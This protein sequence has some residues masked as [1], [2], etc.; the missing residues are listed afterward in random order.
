[1]GLEAILSP[2]RRGFNVAG[3]L[4]SALQGV[5]LRVEERKLSGLAGRLENIKNGDVSWMNNLK[6]MSLEDSALALKAAY[7][8]NKVFKDYFGFATDSPEEWQK[9]NLAVVLA[10]AHYLE[11]QNFFLTTQIGRLNSDASLLSAYA[12]RMG[13]HDMADEEA[14][15]FVVKRLVEQ[16]GLVLEELNRFYDS[17]GG[18]GSEASAFLRKRMTD[19]EEYGRSI[20]DALN[21]RVAAYL[22]SDL[23]D[24]KINPI[25]AKTLKAAGYVAMGG[26]AALLAGLPLSGAAATFEAETHTVP[27]CDQIYKVFLPYMQGGEGGGQPSQPTQPSFAVTC[28]AGPVNDGSGYELSPLG[29]IVVQHTGFWDGYTVL[30]NGALMPGLEIQPGDGQTTVVLPQGLEGGEATVQV[31]AGKTYSSNAFNILNRQGPSILLNI[32][33]SPHPY[34]VL[35]EGSLEVY[36]DDGVAESSLVING[37][38]VAVN[39][40]G[41]FTVN[42][43]YG[44][45]TVVATATDSLGNTST[46]TWNYVGHNYAPEFSIGGAYTVT[47]GGPALILP[48][49]TDMNNDIVNVEI[50]CEGATYNAGNNTFQIPSQGMH[51]DVMECIAS[52]T[53][54]QGAHAT[55]VFSVMYEGTGQTNITL[56]FYDPTPEDP[57]L[58]YNVPAAG[59]VSADDPVCGIESL[60]LEVGGQQVPVSPDGTF[61]T[62]PLPI[63][64][65]EAKVTALNSCGATTVYTTTVSAANYA[66]GFSVEN[67]TVF[68]ISQNGPDLVI[69]DF[70]W[71]INNDIGLVLAFG[72]GVSYDAGSNTLTIS[73][74]GAHNEQI[75][76]EVWAYDP[77]SHSVG[78]YTV[79]FLDETPPGTPIAGEILPQRIPGYPTHT[80]ANVTA[81]AP[82][83]DG[84]NPDSGNVSLLIALYTAGIITDPADCNLLG[85]MG[86]AIN[87]EGGS[88]VTINMEGIPPGE[89][90]SICLIARDEA[91]NYSDPVVVGSFYNLNYDFPGIHT[92]EEIE[93]L[94]FVSSYSFDTYLGSI[95]PL[96]QDQYNRDGQIG[97]AHYNLDNGNLFD[98]NIAGWDVLRQ[99]TGKIFYQVVDPWGREWFF[100][101]DAYYN[102]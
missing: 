28:I 82:Y 47:I 25:V 94:N 72:R 71:D 54:A 44:S 56:N 49:P 81:I 6:P 100:D 95:F 31:V 15:K 41:I 57:H 27:F 18:R 96:I 98:W 26:V 17:F 99:D 11:R 91:L 20:F 45:V 102:P 63:G 40:D 9:A 62:H 64:D 33:G 13:I 30:I 8:G 55:A 92:L 5:R 10:E 46:G 43:P 77:F 23:Q 75:P 48:G 88:E 22:H 16:R 73:S 87:P 78:A 58:P 68:T 2:P 53:D 85:G 97:E 21:S 29:E 89:H 60:G 1:M 52:A 76:F 61:T 37:Q 59:T 24:F 101:T 4:N 19:G 86:A 74:Q 51:G 7:N 34:N 70:T 66:P 90:Y 67:G 35:L 79:L 36:D 83:D 80:T 93:D 3:K 14:R 84:W 42:F 50:A 65:L 39:P 32:P 38:P 69:P 12:A